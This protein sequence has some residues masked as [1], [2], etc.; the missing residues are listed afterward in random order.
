LAVQGFIGFH[1]APAGDAAFGAVTPVAEPSAISPLDAGI[2]DAP[3]R[4]SSLSK[5]NG[6][7]GV[8]HRETRNEQ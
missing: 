6:A 7:V 8:N 2:T 4:S 1:P 3:S 5:R